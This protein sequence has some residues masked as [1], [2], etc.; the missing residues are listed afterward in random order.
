MPV[1]LLVL[2]VGLFTRTETARLSG[3]Q[4]IPETR[5]QKLPAEP[6]PRPAK[7]KRELP[8]KIF[9]NVRITPGVEMVLPPVELAAI[10]DEDQR[11]AARGVKPRR[12]G[13]HR[14]ARVLTTEHGE[15]I[16]LSKGGR[17]WVFALKSPAALGLRVEV[18]ALRLPPQ[19]TLF[20]YSPDDPDKVF[21][22]MDRGPRQGD[23]FWAPLVVGDTV[24]FELHDPA[25]NGKQQPGPLLEIQTISHI[26]RHPLATLEQ[27]KA[28]ACNIDATCDP[29]W[30]S[31]GGAVGRITFSTTGG[32]GTCTGT[33]LNNTSGDFSPVF[34]TA[35]HCI[36]TEA[37]AASAEVYWFY[38]T[39]TCG[40]VPPSLA[41][42]PRSTGA[43]FLAGR[44]RSALS[45]FTLLEILG[46][47]PRTVTVAGWTATDPPVGSAIVG[48]H[49]PQGEFLRIAY[50]STQ[51]NTS[52]NFHRLLWS[53]GTTEPGSSG[54][55]IFNPA[56]Q[57]IGQL[58]GGAAS[59]SNPSGIDEY[60]KLSQ[61]FP[62]MV[63]GSGQN[64][65]QV[66]LGDDPL[67]DNDSRGTPFATGS[68]TF[69]NLVVKVQDED[70][71][72]ITVPPN[73]FLLIDATLTNLHG[74]VDLELFQGAGSTPVAASLGNTDTEQVQFQNGGATTDYF[75]RVFL[76]NDLR[77]AYH[78]TITVSTSVPQT[79]LLTV[80]RSGSGAVSSVPGGIL[81][82]ADC[83]E[84]YLVGAVVTL[85]ATPDPG[86]SFAGWAGC[87]T[88]NGSTCTV[89][90][91]GNRSV[92]AYFGIPPPPNDNYANA[93]VVSLV[94]NTYSNTV[95][96][97]NA[98]NEGLDPVLSCVS[99]HSHGVWYRLTVV[100]SGSVSAN[101]FGSDYDTVLSVFTGSPGSF[102]VVACNDDSSNTLQSS[103]TFPVTAGTTYRFFITSYQSTSGGSL[104]LTVNS[105]VGSI[106]ARKRSGQVI[107]NEE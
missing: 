77:N 3:R 32:T 102:V 79:A 34:L 76:D 67:E 68:A 78:L 55:A 37:E 36:D 63:N 20:L 86:S 43:R 6:A 35:N 49:H 107:S 58:W 94:G 25:P 96:T 10:L 5:P 44:S 104:T 26:Y 24:Y 82:P 65:L 48:L 17:V 87:A 27:P 74:D 91:T 50:G 66:G 92:T 95:N 21:A 7:P 57:V 89:S 41:S 98:T 101:T 14:P 47:A 13:I 103:V 90:M 1:L 18:R 45:D 59:C 11:N 106:G 15:W 81:C 33:M 31:D 23:A 70:W 105:T 39:A 52:T 42:V 88:I 64:Y 2:V 22:F 19:A 72:R 46:V 38:R 69:S 54:S 83:A 8:S 28:G 99:S 85:T 97:T 60:G 29:A 40:G 73:H 100:S 30:T 9:D 62:V 12:I 61:S 75:L 56:H 4:Q 51:T 53:Q 80:M 71:F 84:N 93:S 16:N